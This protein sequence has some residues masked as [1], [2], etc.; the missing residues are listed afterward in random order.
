M[1]ARA[2]AMRVWSSTSSVPSSTKR[3]WPRIRSAAGMFV[4][5]SSTN[6]TKRSRSRL[7]RAITALPSTSSE[8]SRRR[9]NSGH[10]SRAVRRFGGGDEK[11]ARHATHA[12]AGGAVRAALDQD[13]APPRGD[14]GAIRGEAGGAGADDSH[15]Y[16]DLL[17]RCLGRIRCC[18]DYRAV[19]GAVAAA[20]KHG[21]AHA[22]L[23]AQRS[24]ASRPP[25]RWPLMN[26]CG[27]VL[28]PVRA[29]TTRLR[30]VC[31]SGTSA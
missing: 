1:T 6:P 4:T 27:T 15:I 14:R 5:P 19:A 20:I 8:P 10:R 29:P 30:T 26:T 12:R 16:A 25:M 23:R 17:H 2:N 31:A 22:A 11:L 7:T 21:R 9:P 3:A 24:S 13:G 28:S 18:G